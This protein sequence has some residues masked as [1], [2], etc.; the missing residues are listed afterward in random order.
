MM[1]KV[2][3]VVFLKNEVDDIAF[4]LSWHISCGFNTVIAYDDF[5]TDGT[6]EILSSAAKI[7]DIRCHHAVVADQFN[8]RQQKTYLDALDRYRNEFDWLLFLDSDEYL[9]IRSGENVHSF[10]E[11][12]PEAQGLAINWCCYG[13]IQSCN[14]ASVKQCI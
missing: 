2:A 3:V 9:D 14:K 1:S 5:S 6:L 10:L 12:Y 11:K 4:W 8:I 13:S 7:F